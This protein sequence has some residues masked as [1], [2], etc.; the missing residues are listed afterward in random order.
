M[1]Y[2]SKKKDYM[3][4][5]RMLNKV[6]PLNYDCGTLCNEICCTYDGED[7]KNEDLVIVLLPGEEKLFENNDTFKIKTIN[8]ENYNYPESWDIINLFI[9]DNPPYCDRKLRPIQCRT[10]PLDPHLDKNNKLHLV[11]DKESYPYECPIL[12]DNIK[13]NTDFLKTTLKV[14]NILIKNPLTY[15]LVKLESKE[16]KK[17]KIII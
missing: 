1:K 11:Y 3:K 9:C 5:H 4:I 12:R 7:Y 6:T 15:D 13:F 16:R 10:Y 2:P 8:S 17:F 14:W